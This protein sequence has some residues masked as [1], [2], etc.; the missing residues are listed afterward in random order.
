MENLLNIFRNDHIADLSGKASAHLMG[1]SLP[2]LPYPI[3]LTIVSII[4]HL[5]ND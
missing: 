3:L 4:I 2:G 1:N 5:S